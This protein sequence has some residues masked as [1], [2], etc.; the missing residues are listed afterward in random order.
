MPEKY[1]AL[2][3][4]AKAARA[5][6]YS[7]YSGHKVGAAIKTADGEIYGGCNI[8]N[9]S[10]GATNCAE[11]VAIQSAV[12]AIGGIRISEV[13]VVTD[14][15]PPWPPCGICRQVIAEFG[16]EATVIAANLSGEC[17]VMKLAEI[18]PDAFTP[19]HLTK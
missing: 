16:G 17:R 2:Y 8:E 7:P 5:N 19:E 15:T 14:A 4:A 13:M 3:E 18:L 1:M 6:A 10:Y 12:A 9:S 11:R